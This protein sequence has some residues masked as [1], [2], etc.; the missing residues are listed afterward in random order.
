MSQYIRYPQGGPSLP[1]S[2]ANGGT[3]LSAG[4]SANQLL[5][6]NSTATA[7]E[8]KTLAG[9]TSQVVVTNATN[10][11][12]LSLPQ[13]IATTSAPT[14]AGM[15]MTA[16]LQAVHSGVSAGIFYDTAGLITAPGNPCIRLG[17]WTSTT[18][19]F[20]MGMNSTT[21]IIVGCGGSVQNSGFGIDVGGAIRIFPG[22]SANQQLYF[23]SAN[24]MDIGRSGSARNIY[25]GGTTVFNGYQ[26]IAATDAGSATMNNNSNVLVLHFASTSV[27]YTVNFP[28]VPINGQIVSIVTNSTIGT[29]TLVGNGATIFG[30]SSIASYSMGQQ[31][32]YVTTDTAW[33]P[34]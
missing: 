31:W 3:G 24:S 5:G 20:G 12:T 11:V 1:L 30:S 21:E 34:L 15:T 17:D 9:T 8:Y 27:A 4:G 28:S 33:Y 2:I 19:E 18:A 26:R 6:M 16:N 25:L 14:F 10:L 23:N 32:I 22:T 13:S 29:L 7:L